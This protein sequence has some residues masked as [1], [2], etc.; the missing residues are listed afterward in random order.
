MQM[1]V[2]NKMLIRNFDTLINRF[3]LNLNYEIP[4]T[5][6]CSFFGYDK[7]GMCFDLNIL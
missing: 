4:G 5:K 2:S 3:I 7:Y 6:V 1:Y